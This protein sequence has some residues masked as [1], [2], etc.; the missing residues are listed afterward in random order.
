MAH[1][2]VRTGLRFMVYKVEYGAQGY[3]VIDQRTNERVWGPGSKK[4]AQEQALKLNDA[5]V[6]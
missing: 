6:K 1:L 4:D 3:A 5:M 2:E